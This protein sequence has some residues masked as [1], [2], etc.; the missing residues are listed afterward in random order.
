[1]QENNLRSGAVAAIGA[2]ILWGILPLYWKSLTGVTAYEILAHRVCWS[3]LFVILLLAASQRIGFFLQQTRHLL[4]N[5]RNSLLLLGA[6]ILISINW[7]TYIWAVN[8]GRIVE[9]SIGY[10]TNPL[11]SVLLGVVVFHEHLSR[12]KMLSL[13]LAGIGIA[14]MIWNFGQ[15]P[16]VAVIL[17]TTFAVYGAV[18]KTLHMDPMV[19]ILLE[20]LLVMPLALA[21]IFYLTAVGQ[22]NFLTALPTAALLIG[23][24]IVTAVPLLLFSRGANLLPLN[25][26]GFTQYLAPTIALCLGVFVFDEAFGMV[27]LV[28][29]SFI[30]LALLVFSLSGRF[31]ML[32]RSKAAVEK[33][34]QQE[35]IT[36]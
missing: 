33:K 24:G 11:M 27:Q 6:S 23:S 13:I 31:A 28:S 10:Y 18:K 16:W 35:Q 15:V 19:S 7:L 2:C 3:F 30:W 36:N 26:L 20:T 5:R 9:T 25:V 14:N 8:S 4:Q 21:Y 12:G 34:A 22:S 29:F 1:M 32:P 17:A